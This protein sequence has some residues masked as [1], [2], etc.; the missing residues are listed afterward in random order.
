MNLKN[1]GGVSSRIGIDRSAQPKHIIGEKYRLEIRYRVNSASGNAYLDC[2]GGT[3]QPIVTNA[4]LLANVGTGW[5]IA[6]T[7]E[8]TSTNVAVIPTLNVATG[9]A[10]DVDI[11][12]VRLYRTTSIVTGGLHILPIYS[13]SSSSSFAKATVES[14]AQNTNPVST[15][16]SSSILTKTSVSATATHTIPI[17]AGSSSVST[18]SATATGTGTHLQPIYVGSSS[19]STTSATVSGTGTHLQPIY[20]GSSSASTNSATV[21]GTGTHLQPIYVGSS[22]VSTSSATVSTVDTSDISGRLEVVAKATVES[23][24]KKQIL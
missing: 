4:E 17:Y 9:A 3:W 2:Y 13:G 15:V 21:L 23:S 12:W 8:Y 16:T 18:T 1:S 5:Q 6:S 19:V 10:A 20:V 11:D 14:F 24:P 7:P 22:S